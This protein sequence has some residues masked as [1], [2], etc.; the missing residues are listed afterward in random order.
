MRFHLSVE[1]L[2]SFSE[3]NVTD[4]EKERIKLHLRECEECR[5]KYSLLHDLEKYLQE[6]YST[7]TAFT[8]RVVD[9]LGKKKYAKKRTGYI[10]KKRSILKPVF[11]GVLICAFVGASFYFGSK[12]DLLK[13]NSLKGPDGPEVTQASQPTAKPT[14]ADSRADEAVKTA[15]SAR[16]VTLYFP[17]PSAECVVP[18]HREVVVKPDEKIEEVIFREL[19]EGPGGNAE[20]SVIPEGTKLLSVEVKDGICYLNLSTEFVD[21]NPGGT[22][23]ETVLINSIVNSLTEL[24]HIQ[25]VQ[26]LV[27]G[28]KRA[29]YTHLVFDEPFERNESFIR[30]PENTPEAV[31]ERIRELGE[32][33]LAAFKDKDMQTLSRYVHPEK[34]VRF[35]PYTYVEVD[36]DIVITS[37]EIKTLPDNG[38][39]YAWGY[40]DGIGDPIELTFEEYLAEFI[41]DYDFLN[42]DE[43]IYDRQ[44]DRGNTISNVFEVYEGSHI[45]EYY[46]K[47]TPEYD[48]MDW[49]SIKLVFEEKDGTWYLVGVVHDQWTI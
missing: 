12:F 41:Y 28:E 3:G 30:T 39:V 14:A 5:E 32:K 2:D 34:G 9:S 48:G 17:N 4:R 31:E 38:K 22:A 47:G 35:S 26:F 6:E 23:Y 40:Y 10:R 29:V 46:Y 25:K 19:Q 49:R 18:E 43:V 15:D 21:N 36:K 7:D 13:I 44:Y 33:V 37:E 24:P 42:A 20:G 16:R 8:K 1:D 11:S 27:E 45:L